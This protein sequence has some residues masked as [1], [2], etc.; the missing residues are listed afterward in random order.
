MSDTQRH[1][2]F[3]RVAEGGEVETI[4]VPFDELMAVCGIVV[5]EALA[6]REGRPPSREEMLRV[7]KDFVTIMKAA[8]TLIMAE[9]ERTRSG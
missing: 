9:E 7:S 6:E 4:W 2:G 8:L 5:G 1:I 3:R